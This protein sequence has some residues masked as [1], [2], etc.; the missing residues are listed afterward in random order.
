MARFDRRRWR[1]GGL[2]QDDTTNFRTLGD[3]PAP[4]LYG[5]RFEDLPTGNS[6]LVAYAR[7]SAQFGGG[8]DFGL[9]LTANALGALSAVGR[10][11]AEATFSAAATGG[12]NL[13]GEARW[14]TAL[15]IVNGN[16]ETGDATGWTAYTGTGLIIGA[17]GPA[18]STFA[19]TVGANAV[20]ASGQYIDFPTDV[21]PYTDGGRAE[22][23]LDWQ[24][25]SF[26]DADLATVL[27]EFFSGPGGTG[28]LIG[29]HASPKTDQGSGTWAAYSTQTWVP[30]GAQSC[31][32]QIRGVRATG[33]NDD[34]YY[35]NLVG[36]FLIREN[37]HLVYDF[38][39]GNETTGW[40]ATVGNAGSLTTTRVGVWHH[41]SIGTAGWE[42]LVH[43]TT[44]C[45]LYR[46]YDISAAQLTAVDA[47]LAQLELTSQMIGADTDT[48]RVWVEAL[49]ASDVSLG[50]VAQSGA[51]VVNPTTSS[52]PVRAVGT[53]PANART[54]R[55]WQQ[56]TRVSGNNDAGASR[57]GIMV[58]APQDAAPVEAALTAAATSSMSSTGRATFAGDLVAN[59]T[60]T[61][62]TRLKPA[63]AK[64]VGTLW[65]GSSVD[66]DGIVNMSRFSGFSNI[67]VG[68][69]YP[70]Q[71]DT[72]IVFLGIDA[73]VADAGLDFQDQESG[74]FYT[75]VDVE[76]LLP[77]PVASSDLHFRAF[78]YRKLTSS[79]NNSWPIVYC[80][81]AL[82]GQ[83]FIYAVQVWRG[84]DP[85]T[86][87]EQIVVA[88]GTGTSR[89]TPPA[90]TPTR[91]GSVVAIGTLAYLGNSTAYSG[92]GL[93]SIDGGYDSVGTPPLRVFT[94]KFDWVSGTYTPSAFGGG[95]GV[96]ANYGWIA[97]SLSLQPEGF[98]AGITVL[99]A[100]GTSSLSAVGASI[101]SAVFS[102]AAT[103][104]ANIVSQDNAITEAVFSAAAVGELLST[105]TGINAADMTAAATGAMN[106]V[107]TAIGSGALAAAGAGAAAYA[108]NAL[109]PGALSGAASG[110][111][112]AAATALKPAALSGA[113][114]SSASYTG[115]ATYEA[116]FSSAATSSASAAATAI[117]SG[118]LTGSASS[119]MAALATAFVRIVLTALASSSMAAE[120]G[121]TV[122]ATL[123]ADALASAS[124]P[125][126]VLSEGVLS[127]SAS[128][129]LTAVGAYGSVISADNPRV[130]ATF[131][132]A[133]RIVVE[134][135]DRVIFVTAQDRAI[136]MEA[137]PR[138]IYVGPLPRET[139]Q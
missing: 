19:A 37:P 99:T 91:L 57:T 92:T 30:P 28:D 106:L 108:G 72:I 36:T 107:T 134:Q 13:Q 100:S 15:P 86:P 73:D 126:A 34:A 116:T 49:D 81:P 46:D 103:G 129:L 65:N 128:S 83:R 90:I 110:V 139:I 117:S 52:T 85:T 25:A 96:N 42:V 16:F 105:G 133:R 40:T 2:L 5:L 18:G 138:T 80:D 115:R 23:K 43:G 131:S 121:A 69:G 93:Q 97:F 94:G 88:T 4:D 14:G 12:E 79:V 98:D 11:T 47:G 118:T 82:N 111:L 58:S 78:Y 113:A 114:T 67:E 22:L 35:D 55:L 33:T 87:V 74:D 54:L 63:Q 101:A 59:A 61:F 109:A 76:T 124:F 41:H 48:C 38:L 1:S 7:G 29:A 24:G 50:V 120:G 53:I 77:L 20:D 27:I 137:M 104:V 44:S 60:G 89:P 32:L 127:S 71:Y 64:M 125:A 62:N 95:A 9:E 6:Y 119:S 8:G 135:E 10:S 51:A 17:G 70:E 56:K 39:L 102:S 75:A 68:P 136:V 123:S 3:V 132:E 112:A 130:V 26:T 84:L 21:L 45:T 66:A 31:R 122:T